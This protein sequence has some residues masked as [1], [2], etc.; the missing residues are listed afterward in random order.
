IEALFSLH[1]A[2]SALVRLNLDGALDGPEAAQV[3]SLLSLARRVHDA[4]AG[5]FDPTV[6]PWLSALA[7]DGGGDKA[8]G[9]VGLEDVRA[10]RDH[11]AFARPGMALTFNGV[12][13]GLAADRVAGALRDHGFPDALVDAGEVRAGVGRWRVGVE[14]PVRG[15]L[16]TRRIERLG[17]AVSSP[18]ALRIGRGGAAHILHP[19]GRP[20]LWSTV[21]VEARSAALADAVSTA[22][23]F[24]DEDGLR[25]LPARLPG[26]RR[27]LAAPAEG[28]VLRV[29]A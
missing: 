29:K 10:G 25:A 2:D 3:A 24:L 19:D 27:I 28:P 20:A 7:R 23:V 15:L 1:R 17:L 4:A 6:Q 22:A 12:A 14:D 9:L 26:L 5:G 21:A 13:Q 16:E 8:R 11:V 18:G